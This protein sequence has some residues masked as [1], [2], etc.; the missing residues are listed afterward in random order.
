MQWCI[1]FRLGAYMTDQ[2]TGGKWSVN[3]VTYHI[4]IKEMVAVKFALK[5]FVK[6]FSNV[7]IKIFID[8]TTVI[9][10]LKNMGTSHNFHLNSIC[11]QI[12]EWCKDRNIWLF[13]V[14]INTKEDLAD[15]TSRITY[16]Q[17]EWMLEKRLFDSLT[18][19][20]VFTNNRFICFQAKPSIANLCLI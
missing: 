16:I 12:W 13:P 3:E 10:V 15:R 20:K 17:A 5:S 7:S 6:E 1:K 18:N 14:Y 2:N 19:T 11:K 4:N 8:N 9:S